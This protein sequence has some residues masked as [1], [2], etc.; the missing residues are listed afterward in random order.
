LRHNLRVDVVQ[1]VIVQV[2]RIVAFHWPTHR[3]QYTCMF[4]NSECYIISEAE[5]TMARQSR[6]R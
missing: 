6:E 1:H 3:A 2:L 5:D 4:G